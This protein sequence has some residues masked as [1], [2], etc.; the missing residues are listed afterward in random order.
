LQVL[1]GSYGDG[2]INEYFMDSIWD[3]AV[4]HQQLLPGQAQSGA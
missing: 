3:E 2:I 1:A 4:L